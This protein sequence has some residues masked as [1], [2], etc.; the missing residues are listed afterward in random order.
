TST[1]VVGYGFRV[2]GA[3]GQEEEVALGGS[4]EDAFRTHAH[5][6]TVIIPA[7]LAPE[8]L[9]TVEDILPVHRP[10]HTLFAACTVGGGMRVGRGLLLEVS[11]V[12]GRTGGFSTL[13]LGKA[14]LGRGAIVGRPVPGV[15][16][17]SNALGRDTV[18]G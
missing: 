2:G 10:P 14:T 7:V 11:S 6:F 18:V 15:R 17:A 4:I 1:S 12:I 8:Q 3:V 13:Q 16:I 5:R 9:A